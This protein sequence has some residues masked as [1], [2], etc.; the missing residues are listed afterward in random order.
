MS[1]DGRSARA[2]ARIT[3]RDVAALAGVSLATVS[4][5]ANGR[6]DVAPE[7]RETVLGV[8]R[9]HGFATNRNARA[10]AGGRTGLIGFTVPFL[11]ESYFTAILAGAAEAAYEQDQRVVICPTHHEHAR[12]V[13]LLERLM[14]G[15]TDGSIVLLP[16]ESS[17]ELSRL[18][19]Q[20]YPFVVADP[21]QPLDEGIPTVSAA[22]AAGARAAVD[23]LLGLGHRRIA[24]ITGTP[25]WVATD[26]RVLGYRLSLAAAGIGIDPALADGGDFTFA[27]GHAVAERL[28]ALADPPTA[29]FACNDNLAVG[30][31]HAAVERGLRIPEDLSVVGFDDTGL[32]ESVF[33]SLTTVRQPLEELGRTAVSLLNRIVQGQRTEAL[34]IELSTRLVVRE[35]TA[36]A[37]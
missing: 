10:L 24:L 36:A 12:E 15:T 14:G 28:L 27:T 1:A 4:R 3:I 31:M 11:N 9:E 19:N 13:T 5:V 34:R 23:H 35:S 16:E 18:R 26:E 6:P 33:P 25:R 30:A 8:M 22:H 32:A 29:I 37:L 20:G 7:T 17:A 2:A 21:R